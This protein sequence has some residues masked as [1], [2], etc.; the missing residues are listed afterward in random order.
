MAEEQD[1]ALAAKR[2]DDVRSPAAIQGD[3]VA[4]DNGVLPSGTWLRKV[5]I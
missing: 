5:L 4:E 3:H 2:R 1:V